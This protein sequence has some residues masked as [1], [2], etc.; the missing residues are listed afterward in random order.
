MKD[1]LYSPEFILT[2]IIAA[3][4]IIG[5]IIQLFKKTDDG[6]PVKSTT[7]P[8]QSQ[9]PQA[10]SYHPVYLAR[11]A[12]VKRQAEARGDT[13]TVQAVLNMTYK[14]ALPTM[15]PDGT[16]T[17]LRSTILSYKIAGINFRRGLRDY[18]GDFMGEL[19]P[20]PKNKYDHNAIAIH[21]SDGKHLGYIHAD[22][23]DDIRNLNIPF[24]IT[25][26]GE[27]EEDYDYDERRRFYRGN[28]FVEAQPKVSPSNP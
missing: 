14:G 26:W 3:A 21:H 27:I 10:R 2:A 25:I 19:R 9:Q 15:K 28:I 8:V 22:E 12:E 20:E 17:D 18:V 6:H 24:P 1:L 11:L 7:R 16:F 23:T 4:G 5:L 13:A